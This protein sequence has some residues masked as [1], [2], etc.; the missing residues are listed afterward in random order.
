MRIRSTG[1]SL[2][3]YGPHVSRQRKHWA[4]TT[5]VTLRIFEV[6][7]SIGIYH[8]VI[9]PNSSPWKIP[10][11]KNAKPSINGPCYMEN[12][13]FIDGPYLG[14]PIENGDIFHSY[15]PVITFRG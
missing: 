15:G 9:K 3:P 12:G 1:T 13:P 8:L 5:T 4:S 10:I 11:L 2:I 7:E 6:Y 14:L